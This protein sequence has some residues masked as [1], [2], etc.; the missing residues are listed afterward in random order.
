VLAAARK[1]VVDVPD[2][3]N[4]VSVWSWAYRLVLLADGGAPG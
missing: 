3:Q 4:D 1:H 2:A